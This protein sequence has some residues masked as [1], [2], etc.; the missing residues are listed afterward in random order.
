[1]VPGYAVWPY[2]VLAAAL[3]V[4]RGA[5]TA[6]PRPTLLARVVLVL[7]LG[8]LAGEAFFPLPVG[9]AAATARAAAAAHVHGASARAAVLR[10]V[11]LVPLRSIDELAG[12]LPAWPA[13]RALVGNVLVFVP[14]G[15]LLPLAAPR[16]CRSWRA[17]LVTALAVTLTIELGQL[18]V[19]L[20]LGFA[21]RVTELDDVLLN[22]AGAMLGW[23]LWRTGCLG[24]GALLDSP[25]TEGEGRPTERRERVHRPTAAAGA[26]RRGEAEGDGGGRRRGKGPA[27]AETLRLKDRD[28]TGPRT[29]ATG[30][31]GEAGRPSYE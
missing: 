9:A 8:W 15:P 4:A 27:G 12:R 20:A 1:V 22:T 11:D 7:Y 18:T 16:R 25:C 21:Y 3:I 5:A 10:A 30:H 6:T 24:R 13:V 28:A 31:L 2:A 26:L 23:L 17:I 19:S 14:L 29:S